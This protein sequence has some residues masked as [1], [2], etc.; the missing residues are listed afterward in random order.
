MLHAQRRE[1]HGLFY[2]ENLKQ[3]GHLKDT[4]EDGRITLKPIFKETGWESTD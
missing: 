4:D 1:I 3:R 2:W